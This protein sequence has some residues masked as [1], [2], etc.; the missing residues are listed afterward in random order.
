MTKE[1]FLQKLADLVGQYKAQEE[2]NVDFEDVQRNL[3]R[4]ES[5]VTSIES[6]CSDARDFIR[7]IENELPTLF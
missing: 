7:A 4:L 2:P 5:E 6:A 1:E 3:D